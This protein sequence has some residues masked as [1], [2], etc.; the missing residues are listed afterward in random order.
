MPVWCGHQ[1]T[2]EDYLGIQPLSICVSSLWL[3]EHQASDCLSFQPLTEHKASDCLS[4]KSL[5]EHPASDCLSI[6]PLTESPFCHLT[7]SLIFSPHLFF[8]FFHPLPLL[9][10]SFLSPLPRLYENFLKFER[11][12]KKEW[13]LFLHGSSIR[14]YTHTKRRAHETKKWN[15]NNGWEKELKLQVRPQ[16]E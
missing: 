11:R 8:S 4:I 15:I 7:F 12:K 6:Q 16:N 10:H 5:T 3:S 2:Q 13:T 14:V 1:G 9:L